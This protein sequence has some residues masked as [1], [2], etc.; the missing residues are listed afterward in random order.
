M[1]KKGIL[2]SVGFFLLLFII[3]TINSVVIVEWLNRSL[4][5]DFSI[6]LEHINTSFSNGVSLI[7]LLTVLIYSIV[8]T[9]IVSMVITNL[10]FG[11]FIVANS[12]KVA[13]RNEFITF[14]EL[15]A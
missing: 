7:F 4:F 12:I 13:E 6:D 10:L 2:F 14:S 8:G 1:S 5:P 11:S 3:I 15:Q 9:F